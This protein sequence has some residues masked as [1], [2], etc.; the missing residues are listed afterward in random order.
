VERKERSNWATPFVWENA[1]RTEIVTPG[2]DKV[3]SYD[4]EGKLLWEFGGMS[5]ISIPTP[6]AAEGLLFVSSGYILDKLR[7]VYAI[8]PGARGDITLAKGETKN[9]FIVWCQAAAGPYHPSP[10]V[11]QGRVYVLLDKGF[12]SCYDAK[13]GREI[14]HRERIAPGSDMFTASPWAYDGKIFC[15]SEDG[16]TFVIRAGPKFEVLGRNRLEEMCL[17]TPAIARDSLVLRTA[18]KVYRIAH[19]AKAK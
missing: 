12:L 2:T 18:S 13:T 11:Y 16:D 5:S 14:Y 10:V 17:A 7:P 4:L 6:S 1:L 19:P 8:K 15:L 9:E 3:R